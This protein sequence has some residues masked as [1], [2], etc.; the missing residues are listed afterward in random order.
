MLVRE[1][2]YAIFSSIDEEFQGKKHQR[3]AY[4]NKCHI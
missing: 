3:D 4:D 1:Q 2:K